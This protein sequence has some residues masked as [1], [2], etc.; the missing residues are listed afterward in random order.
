MFGCFHINS[1][2]IVKIGIYLNQYKNDAS[3]F[4]GNKISYFILTFF[5]AE[6]G[7]INREG[8]TI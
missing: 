5:K 6:S 1:V 4:Q 3:N 2:L 7:P 8:A